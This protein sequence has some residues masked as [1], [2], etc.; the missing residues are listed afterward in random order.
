MPT[1]LAVD[2]AVAAAL[3]EALTEDGVASAVLDAVCDHLGAVTASLWLLIPDRGE[4]VLGYE[5]NGHPAA[6]AHLPAG[7]GRA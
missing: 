6:V 4:P 5:R 7:A 3:G 2:R 1:R